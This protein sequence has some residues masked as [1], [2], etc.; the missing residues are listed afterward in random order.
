MLARPAAAQLMRDSAT[1]WAA[2]PGSEGERYLRALQVAGESPATQ[3]SIRPFSDHEVR[4]LMPADTIHPWAARLVVRPTGRAWARIIQPEL[5]EIVNSR[6]PYGMD[7]GPLWAGRGPTTSAIVGVE[8]GVGPLEFTLAP[9][10]F[11]AEN[12][13]FPIA[14]NG[15]TGPLAYGDGIYATSID[16]PQ[17][18]GDGPYQRLD[19]GQSGVRLRL[20]RLVVGAST[21]NE[22]WGPSIESP[23]LLGNN[24]AGFAHLIAGTDGPL[25]LGPFRTS[26]RIIVGRL[27][28]SD[29]APPSPSP[30]RYIAGAIVVVGLHQVPGLEVGIARLFENAWPDSGVRLTTVLSQLLKNPFKVRLSAQLGGDGTEADNQIASAFVRWNVP[31]AGIELYGE[32]GREDNAYDTRDLLVQPDR[33]A[34]YSLGMQ[35]VWTRGDGSLFA[36]RGEVLNS[37]PSHLARVRPSGPPYVHTPVAQGHTQ[38]GQILGAPSAFAGGGGMVAIEWITRTGRRSI[39]W[40]RTLHEPVLFPGPKDVVHAITADWLMF[41]PRV[42]LAPEATVA[43][44][45]NRFQIGDVVNFRAA[46]TAHVHW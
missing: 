44:N 18:F 15:Q 4:R 5:T 14:V 33:D 26:A 9:Q 28:Q 41:R 1:T 21:G 20:L 46:L 34:S 6:F 29:Y 36:L 32:M 30:R 8:G 19:P 43:Y 13:S 37:A 42:D 17:R 38:L 31:G 40:R 24:A 2:G 11:R 16:L 23:F 27:D 25:D 22:V 7:D 39:T 10:L 3:W 45:L 12:W 35:R